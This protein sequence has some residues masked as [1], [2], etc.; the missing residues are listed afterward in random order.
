MTT[1]LTLHLPDLAM[2]GVL[3][4][5]LGSLAAAVGISSAWP[6]PVRLLRLRRERQADGVSLVAS[7][8]GLLCTATW[9]GYGVL[10]HDRV[11]LVTNL[12]CLVAASAVVTLVVLAGDR[13]TL[14]R[15]CGLAVVALAAWFVLAS[16]LDQTGG[17]V[18][19][20]ALG[21]ALSL[22]S[23]LPQVREVF[24]ATSLQGLSPAACVLSAG[25]ALLWTGYGLGRGDVAVTV[26][27][28]VCAVLNT[29]VLARRCPPRVVVR[30]LR[31]AAAPNHP[32]EHSS[33]RGRP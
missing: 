32:T 6:Q 15:R 28:A 9:L 29:V 5:T 1:S 19:V 27:S 25:S 30:P 4:T 18:L 13:T 3:V 24:V 8:L 20:G 23:K 17:A 21:S 22:L 12:V 10:A 2:P 16:G 14:S 7:V 26:T 11:Q 31:R 33:E